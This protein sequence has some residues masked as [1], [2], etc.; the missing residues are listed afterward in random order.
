MQAQLRGTRPHLLI[1]E[2][3]LVLLDQLET[4]AHA[5]YCLADEGLWQRECGPANPCGALLCGL[6]LGGVELRLLRSQAAV[7]GIPQSVIEDVE[8]RAPWWQAHDCYSELLLH[9]LGRRGLVAS[10]VVVL[11]HD[12]ISMGLGS[13]HRVG[14]VGVSMSDILSALSASL[15]SS[16]VRHSRPECECTTSGLAAYRA[17]TVS[18]WHWQTCRTSLA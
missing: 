7:H 9:C 18:S 1:N 10:G 3:A 13:M 4:P 12:P 8:V 15:C 11:H 14:L 2:A 6:L 5:P 16:N 17:P